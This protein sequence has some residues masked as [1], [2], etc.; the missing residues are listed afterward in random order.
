MVQ[1][2]DGSFYIGITNDAERR[3][4]EHNLGTDP[5]CYTF[6]RRPVTLVYSTAFDYVRDAIA[7]EKR[8]KGWSRAKKDALVRGDWEQIRKLSKSKASA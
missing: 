8:I 4:A 3:V 5:R 1:C 2:D 6:K 7:W